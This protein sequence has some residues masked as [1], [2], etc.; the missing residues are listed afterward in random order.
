VLH[1]RIDIVVGCAGTVVILVLGNL[2]FT[3]EF[4][5]ALQLA[6]AIKVQA[7]LAKVCSG[8]DS[9]AFHCVGVLHDANAAPTRRQQLLGQLPELLNKQG[10]AVVATGRMVV[11]SIGRTTIEL[12]FAVAF[13]L[14]QWLRVRGK[15]AKSNAGEHAHWAEIGN[16]GAAEAGE[17]PWLS[18]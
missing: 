1:Q 12:P 6:A 3:V 7:R 8:D 2:R 4:P 16:V 9:R 17:R 5:L 10:I 18:S 11:V 14:A 13:T 15:E